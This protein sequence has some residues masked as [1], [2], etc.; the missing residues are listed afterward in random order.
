MTITEAA[1]RYNRVTIMALVTLVAAGIGAF[2]SLPRAEDPGFIIKTALVT[3]YLPG[4]SPE[5][6]ELLVSD[7]IEE[8][9]QEIP[10]LDFVRSDSRTGVSLVF[11]NIRSEYKEM[12]P[13][14]DDLRRKVERV[15]SDLP[16]GVVGPFVNDEFGDVYPIMISLTG[17]GYSFAELKDVADEVRDELLRIEM[18]AKVDIYGAQEERIFVEYD[19]ARL[20]EV[21]LSPSQLQ[22]ILAGQNILLSGGTVTV[23]GEDIAIE[24]SGSFESVE[25]LRRTLIEVPGSGAVLYL[26]DLAHVHRGTVDPPSSIMHSSGERSLGLAVSMR[27]GGNVS[28]LGVAV[29]ALLDRLPTVYPIGLD[30]EA[31]IFQPEF[32]DQ[33]IGDFVENLGQAIGIVL[34]V[35]VLTL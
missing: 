19:N 4:A 12:R 23:G 6:M 31:T 3:T 13:I 24:P 29:R 1:I 28:E 33:K 20:A 11:V 34:L 14:W 17:D 10:E 2:Y 15:A 35:M 5:R 22:Q 32:V 30:F 9:V 26:G 18:V 8:V 21:G 16:S 27:E 25:D 7:K